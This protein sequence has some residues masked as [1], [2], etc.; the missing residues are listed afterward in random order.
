MAV[1][2]KLGGKASREL[3]VARQN[4]MES[5]AAG[6]VAEM[7]N[8]TIAAKTAFSSLRCSNIGDFTSSVVGWR[9]RKHC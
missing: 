4:D 7:A 3:N 9:S 6:A 2:T 1:E 5:P 8:R